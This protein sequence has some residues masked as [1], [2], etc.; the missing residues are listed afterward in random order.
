MGSNNRFEGRPLKLNVGR[1]LSARQGHDITMRIEPGSTLCF[2]FPELPDKLA[3]MVTGEYEPAK[4]TA[5]LPETFIEMHDAK[6]E[7]PDKYVAQ[8]GNWIRGEKLLK[9]EEGAQYSAT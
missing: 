8:L 2:E 3:S 6:H 5:T 7:F 9:T 1:L 4:L